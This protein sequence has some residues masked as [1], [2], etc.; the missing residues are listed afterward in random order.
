MGEEGRD[1]DERREQDG[2]PRPQPH[3]QPYG[4]R[5]D[6]EDPE[7]VR[8]E[9]ER[10]DHAPSHQP[11]PVATEREPEG[12]YRRRSEQREQRVRPSLL[13]V[14]DEE[15]ARRDERGRDDPRASGHENHPGSVRDRDRRGPREGGERPQPD[16]AEPEDR[17]P[18]PCDDVVEVRRRLGPR[19]LPEDVA[20]SAIEQRRGDELVEPEALPVEGREA[21]HG[22]EQRERED[23]PAPHCSGTHQADK[24]RAGP[25]SPASAASAVTM[26]SG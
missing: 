5:A 7:V 18:E 20:E 4:L 10:T 22:A 26:K 15:R 9:R 13:R 14:P 25:Q 17:A 21:E 2:E 8:G 1:G 3:E 6:E 11:A 24:R 16:L 12:E 23:R 19:D